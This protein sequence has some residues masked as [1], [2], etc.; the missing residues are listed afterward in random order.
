VRAHHTV[1]KQTRIKAANTRQSQRR[2]GRPRTTG[3][4]KRSNPQTRQQGR[5]GR[6]QQESPSAP[7]HRPANTSIKTLDIHRPAN[8]SIKTLDSA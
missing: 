1:D 5:T 3:V 8:T 7:I 2:K 6:G 4:A